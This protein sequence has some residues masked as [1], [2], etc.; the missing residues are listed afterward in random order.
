MKRRANVLVSVCLCVCANSFVLTVTLLCAQ[1]QRRGES[2]LR[3]IVNAIIALPP[4]SQRN[5]A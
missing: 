3:T 1:A 2:A 5:V 4:A